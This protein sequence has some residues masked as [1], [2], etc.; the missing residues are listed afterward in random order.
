VQSHLPAAHKHV[1]EIQQ[2]GAEAAA[3]QYKGQVKHPS[4]RKQGM[5][6]QG[7]YRAPVDNGWR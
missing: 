3:G 5:Y 7:E 1:E 4:C 6:I 2:D